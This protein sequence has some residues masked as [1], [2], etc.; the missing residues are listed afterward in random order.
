MSSTAKLFSKRY[1]EYVDM[2][3]AGKL[4]VFKKVPAQEQFRQILVALQTTSHPWLELERHHESPS[5]Q[6]QHRHD[7]HVEPLHRNLFAAR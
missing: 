6:Q 2:A 4:R 1:Q 5:A 3:E 7:S